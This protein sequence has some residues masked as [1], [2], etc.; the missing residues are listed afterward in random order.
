M[1]TLNHSNIKQ[2]LE[3]LNYKRISLEQAESAQLMNRID[4]KY[5]LPLQKVLNILHNCKNHY[6]IVENN[7]QV[8]LNYFSE[9]YDTEDRLMYIDHHNRRPKRYKIRVR[10]YIASGDRFLE[11]KLKTPSGQTKKKRIAYIGNDGLK[12]EAIDFID[13]YSPYHAENLIHTLTTQF[14]RI[15]LVSK[16]YDER[17]TL[18]INLLISTPKGEKKK[19]NNISIIEV[20]RDK[21]KNNSFLTQLLK[22]NSIRPS[23]FSKYSVGTAFLYPSF[24][25]NTFKE[26]LLQINKIE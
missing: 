18:D 17:A 9:Y 20:K 8:L 6:N 10:T 15:T 26:I 16:S 1:L 5:V 11:I 14:Y 2:Q 7:N 13:K 12:N 24:K 4:S 22:V 19:F 21:A 23:R 25:I 3:I